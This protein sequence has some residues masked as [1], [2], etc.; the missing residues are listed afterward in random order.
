VS[1]GASLAP[2][3][4]LAVGGRDL[5]ENLDELPVAGPLGIPQKARTGVGSPERVLEPAHDVVVRI[6]GAARAF[7]HVQ[8]FR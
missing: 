5:A 1:P 4:R 8:G 7:I 2:V 3:G 6:F